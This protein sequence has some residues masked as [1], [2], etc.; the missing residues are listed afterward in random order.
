MRLIKLVITSCLLILSACANT[1]QFE[2][3]APTD[4]GYNLY[5]NGVGANEQQAITDALANL[6]LRLSSNVSTQVH[7]LLQQSRTELAVQDTSVFFQQSSQVARP[8]TFNN[9]QVVKSQ[10]IAEQTQVTIA[11]AKQPFF[12]SLHKQSAQ[13]LS[14]LAQTQM[15]AKEQDNLARLAVSQFELKRLQQKLYKDIALLNA[16]SYPNTLYQDYQQLLHNAI[17]AAANFNL[18]FVAPSSLNYLFDTQNLYQNGIGFVG[19]TPLVIYVTGEMTLG[20]F[21]QVTAERLT[22]AINLLVD[23]NNH[24]QPL[25]NLNIQAVENDL[26]RRQQQLKQS[27]TQQIWL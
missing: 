24:L 27:L 19:Q 8:F 16:F 20:Q 7:T 15:Q 2:L 11:V 5:A 26:S 17:A 3:N 12:D 1:A 22:L 25:T 21:N 23:T 18:R 13:K 10:A 4:D 14:E 9:Y 6:S